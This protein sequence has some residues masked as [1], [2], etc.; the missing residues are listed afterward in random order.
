MVGREDDRLLRDLERDRDVS[1]RLRLRL[2]LRLLLRLRLLL[3]PLRFL[4]PPFDFFFLSPLRLLEDE[5]DES[6]LWE[7]RDRERDFLPFLGLDFDLDLDLERERLMLFFLLAERD[8]DLDLDV[9]RV[10][11]RR[12]VVGEIFFP[13]AMFISFD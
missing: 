12:F 4:L 9:D 2:L 1:R 5:R 8:L 3:F 7:R 6:E 10:R 11:L 13:S